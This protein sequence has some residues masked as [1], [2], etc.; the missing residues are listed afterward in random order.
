MDRLHE[1]LKCLRRALVNRK[2]VILL[3]DNAKPHTAIIVRYKLINLNWE[4]LPHPPYSPDI[5]P[6]D[7]YL[8]RS[9][10]NHLNDKTFE[11][12]AD[13]EK[14]LSEHFSF[15]SSAFFHRRIYE[16]PERWRQVIESD[17]GYFVH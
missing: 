5:A 3:H 16:L 9:S 1:E 17:G 12:E 8:F 13:L 14:G 15:H 2:E 7:Y 11:H 10:Q 6:S 4:V